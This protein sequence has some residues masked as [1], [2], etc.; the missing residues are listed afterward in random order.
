MKPTA[1]IICP[2]WNNPEY[3][4]PCVES[5]AKT[6]ALD[7]LCELIVVNN[8]LQDMDFMKNWPNTTIL[9]PGKNLGWEGGLEL[10]LKHAKGEFICFQNDDTLIPKATQNFYSQLLW[11]F[12]NK[13]VAA[14]G[15]ATTVAAGVHSIFNRQ[16]PSTLT[17]V[18]FLIFFTVMI[19]RSHLEEAGGIDSSAPGGDDFDI[20]IRLRKM[21]KNLLIN[22]D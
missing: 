15:P 6:G 10:G 20:S 16:S 3:F 12:Q 22:P 19:R 5:I 11:P 17:E 4:T 18:T 21:G 2:T 9:T 13:N 8:G 1:S 14:V 7:G